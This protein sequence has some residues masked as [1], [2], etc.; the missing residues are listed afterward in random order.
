[1]GTHDR[2][3]VPSGLP[4]QK[5]RKVQLYREKKKK[6]RKLERG[7]RD[8]THSQDLELLHQLIPF[9]RSV[10]QEHPLRPHSIGYEHDSPT[11]REESRKKKGKGKQKRKRRWWRNESQLRLRV[12][13]VPSAEK[14][15]TSLHNRLGTSLPET[16]HPLLLRFLSL[17]T[18]MKTS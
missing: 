14:G 11:D 18:K 4:K 8:E 10:D 15:L 7:E 17:R 5:A 9:P 1:M 16:S 2:V 3:D 13:D 12:P 6:G